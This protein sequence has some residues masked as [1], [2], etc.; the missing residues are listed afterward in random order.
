MTD[1]ELEQLIQETSEQIEKL[2]DTEK[3]LDKE[4]KKQKL[5]RLL[6][7]AVSASSAV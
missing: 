7:S 4:E 5:F 1:E 2:S 3:P 6:P